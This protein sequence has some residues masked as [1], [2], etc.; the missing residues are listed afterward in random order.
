M[1]SCPTAFESP[2]WWGS[3][4]SCFPP[5]CPW[6]SHFRVQQSPRSKPPALWLCLTALSVVRTHCAHRH[7]GKL[8]VLVLNSRPASTRSSLQPRDRAGVFLTSNLSHSRIHLFRQNRKC[9]NT[10]YEP[11]SI[12]FQWGR[13]DKLQTEH[14]GKIWCMSVIS[15]KQK[16]RAVKGPRGNQGWSRMARKGCRRNVTLVKAQGQGLGAT[17]GRT[18]QADGPANTKGTCRPG[19]VQEQ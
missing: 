16:N 18:C 13:V 10:Y 17:G 4:C 8:E 1:L 2:L 9:L 12:L 3:M 5:R 19:M 6:T 15:G 11:G 14:G 7:P